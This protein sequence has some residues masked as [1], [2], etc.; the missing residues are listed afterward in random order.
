MRAGVLAF[1]FPSL[2]W[3]YCTTR[4]FFRIHYPVSFLFFTTLRDSVCFDLFT[5]LEKEEN[6]FEERK[7][8]W[9][10]KE[11]EKKS[12][13]DQSELFILCWLRID[14]LFDSWGKIRDSQEKMENKS[15]PFPVTQQT[16]KDGEPRY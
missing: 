16:A 8:S 15:I 1:T 4:A 11:N 7:P 13:N 9:Q 5:T 14:V 6:T 2:L 12:P 3:L 10:Q